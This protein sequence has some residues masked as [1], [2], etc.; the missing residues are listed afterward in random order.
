MNG[1][2][3]IVKSSLLTDEQKES[4]LDAPEGKVKAIRSELVDAD[5]NK[6]VIEAPLK[7]SQNGSLS[8]RFNV[9]VLSFDLVDVD[10]KPKKESEK[11]EEVVSVDEM[12]QEI[13]SG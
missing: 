2:I 9:K 5:G 4:I 12:A 13:L 8:G 6:V 3:T 11:V 10:V 1:F 7:I